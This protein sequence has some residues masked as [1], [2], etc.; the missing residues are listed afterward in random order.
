MSN[1]G[2]KAI[3]T[4]SSPSRASLSSQSVTKF[5]GE[6]K[7]LFVISL[8][9]ISIPIT[10]FFCCL[11]EIQ[12]NMGDRMCGRF[13]DLEKNRVRTIDK[14]DKR[15]DNLERKIDG[16]INSINKSRQ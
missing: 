13:D 8:C 6:N 1:R 7:S 3:A 16:V 10:A 12:N 9:L 15:F 4:K 11:I 2:Y 14:F 5:G